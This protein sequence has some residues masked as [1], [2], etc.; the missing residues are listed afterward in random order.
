M[1]VFTFF[2]YEQTRETVRVSL[3]ERSHRVRVRSNITRALT[4]L[5]LT[6]VSD[7][8]QTSAA[9]AQCTVSRMRGRRG[10]RIGKKKGNWNRQRKKSLFKQTI[11]Q[12]SVFFF[13]GGESRVHLWGVSEQHSEQAGV[14]A[15]DTAKWHQTGH[16]HPHWDSW[17]HPEHHG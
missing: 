6:T 7:I 12:L 16:R 15:W 2:Q 1:P 14:H 17:Q 4:A 9:L 5:D 8:Q 10:G 3:D 13:P 11:D